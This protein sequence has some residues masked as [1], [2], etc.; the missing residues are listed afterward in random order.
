MLLQ[1]ITLVWD[2][3]LFRSGFVV[4]GSLACRCRV[5][6]CRTQLRS[7]PAVTWMYGTYHETRTVVRRAVGW[8]GHRRDAQEGIRDGAARGAHWREHTRADPQDGQT[9]APRHSNISTTHHN[10][11]LVES[12]VAKHVHNPWQ[13]HIFITHDNQTC[14]KPRTIKHILN[15]L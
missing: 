7:L 10:Q 15:P 6:S 2:T 1:D 9:R 4:D 3:R 5:V 14:V 13:P 12:I 11:R 8:Q